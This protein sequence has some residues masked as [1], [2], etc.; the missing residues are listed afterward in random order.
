MAE[1]QGRSARVQAR[2]D[3]QA[4]AAPFVL[5]RIASLSLIDP[6]AVAI[7]ER[8][9]DRILDEIGI[10]AHALPFIGHDRWHAY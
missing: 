9:A 7:I 8:N 10:D 3:R 2:S 1:R 4:I 5:R 6:E